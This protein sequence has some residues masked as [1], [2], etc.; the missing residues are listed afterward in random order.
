M[1]PSPARA[2]IVPCGP[3][4]LP[5]T[6]ARA[7][8]VG[9]PIGMYRYAAR[10]VTSTLNSVAPIR[11]FRPHRDNVAGM[12]TALSEMAVIKH[13]TCGP[14]GNQTFGKRIGPALLDAAEPVR[15]HHDRDPLMLRCVFR[16]MEP[17]AFAGCRRESDVM[18][19]KRGL[20]RGHRG[21]RSPLIGSNC[22][23]SHPFK[24]SL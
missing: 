12:A 1:S 22:G 11:Q 20:R 16:R 21:L 18:A 13:K 2:M 14:V 5:G 8:P 17:P 19:Y 10:S 9:A 3:S 23:E 24:L 15:H 4:G 6:V 7:R